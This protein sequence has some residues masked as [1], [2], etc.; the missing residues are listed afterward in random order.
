MKRKNMTI[1]GL[2][3]GFGLALCIGAVATQQILDKDTEVSIDQLPDAVKATLETQ[4]NS[5]VI[6]EIEI[7]KED[8]QTVYEAEV[9][10]DGAEVD[11]LIA[12]D[13]TL[14]GK[15]TEDDDDGDDDDDD[16]DDED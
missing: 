16:G 3:A 5:G 14:L 13:G 6:N 15:E 2:V 10:I 7:E 11:I 4:A 9:L 8:G 1:I 12:A